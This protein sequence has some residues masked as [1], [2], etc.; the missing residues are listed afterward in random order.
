MASPR[1]YGYKFDEFIFGNSFDLTKGCR[2]GHW[3]LATS[4]DFTIK[5][6]DQTC[7]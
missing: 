7:H 5:T 1:S 3:D 6:L 4:Q 2:M